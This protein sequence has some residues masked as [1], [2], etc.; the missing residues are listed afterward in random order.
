MSKLCGAR[1]VVTEQKLTRMD[2]FLP[3]LR[4]LLLHN[5]EIVRLE[6]LS[7][8]P[9]L[10]RLWLFSNRI[11]KIENL[12]GVGDLREL[13]LQVH[14]LHSRRDYYMTSF[15]FC[16]NSAREKDWHCRKRGTQAT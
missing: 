9:R 7:G 1:L 11:A 5:N 6:G 3:N 4:D 14:A 13:W 15:S 10:Q 2:L 12:D 16:D 8:C